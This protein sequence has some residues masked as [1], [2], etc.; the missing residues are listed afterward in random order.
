MAK[1]E[2]KTK[3][4]EASVDAFIDKQPEAVAGDCRA[5][6]KLMKKATG[7]EPKMW[8]ASIVGFGRY[9]YEGASGR[10]GE[11]MVTGFSPRK[12]NLTLYIMMGFEKEAAQMKKLGK[13]TTGKSCLYIKRL[14]D[15]DMKVL[16]ELIVKG[17]KAMAKTRVK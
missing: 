3:V 16:E 15:V 4:N 10:S 17:V 14:G 2:L 1:A 13:H 8:G 7:E 5:I 12:T 6:M 9:A 11:W